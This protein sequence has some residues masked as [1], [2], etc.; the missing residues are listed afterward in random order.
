M[1]VVA[2]VVVVAALAW[3]ASRASATVTSGP[4]A[5]PCSAA[6][7]SAHLTHLA[8]RGGVV[9]Y[10]CEGSWA[11]VWATVSAGPTEVS[12]TELM[13]YSNEGWRAVSRATFCH[14]DVLPSNVYR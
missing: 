12:V 9:A 13:R 3:V 1:R 4:V 5:A 2:S 11:Y 7:V 14:P 8:P 10:G 6:S